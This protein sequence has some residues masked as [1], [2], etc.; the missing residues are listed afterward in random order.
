[1][2]NA[3]RKLLL[4]VAKTVV[5]L[6]TFSLERAEALNKAIQEVGEESEERKKLQAHRF[7][8]SYRP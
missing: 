7:G 8:S 3:E 6:C 4:L 5:S 2:T 1:M